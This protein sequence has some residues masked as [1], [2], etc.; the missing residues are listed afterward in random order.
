MWLARVAPGRA[1]PKGAG[2]RGQRG[3]FF[4]RKREKEMKG[5][6]ERR[7]CKF[8]KGRIQSSCGLGARNGEKKHFRKGCS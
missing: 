4:K 8:R 1:C 6:R 7:F 2:E 5:R 3:N